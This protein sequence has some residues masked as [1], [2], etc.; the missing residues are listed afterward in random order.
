MAYKNLLVH[1]DSGRGCAPRVDVAVELAQAYEAH[2]AGLYVAASPY[3]PPYIDE[4][5]GMPGV[6]REARTR[7]VH[8]MRDKA[9]GIFAERTGRAGFSAEWRTAE[10]TSVE[11]PNVVA[12]HA[13]YADLAIVGQTDPEGNGWATPRDLPERLVM[14]A[15]R[16][17]LVVP[18]VGKYSQV[19]K[20]VLVAWNATREATRAVNDALPI[21]ERAEAVTVLAVDPES[22]ISGHGEVPGAD[23]ALHLARHGVKAEASHIQATDV[24]VGDML[25]SRAA[26]FSADLIVMG[27]YGHSRLRELVLGGATEH[28]LHHMT[29]PVLMAH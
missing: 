7:A 11:V 5:G 25:L 3:M 26:D 14:M 16:P 9:K 17:M 4:A 12:L 27:A 22:G 2:L 15:G 8:E 10:T 13:R 23:I 1:V 20:R 18:Y 28:I 6:V 19:G 24:D 29:M 21:L